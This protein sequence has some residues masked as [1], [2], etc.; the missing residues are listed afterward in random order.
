MEDS[1]HLNR[2]DVVLAY[3]IIKKGSNETDSSFEKQIPVSENN[4][5]LQHVLVHEFTDIGVYELS[6]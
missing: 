5:D 4:L 6:E 1:G 2:S 3:T